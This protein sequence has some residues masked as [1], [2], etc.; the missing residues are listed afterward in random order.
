MVDYVNKSQDLL[1]LISLLRTSIDVRFAIGNNTF[2]VTSYPIELCN[3]LHSCFDFFEQWY[4][5]CSFGPCPSL[6][7]GFICNGVLIIVIRKVNIVRQLPPEQKLSLTLSISHD[8]GRIM[9][10]A[11]TR[12]SGKL[13]GTL[14]YPSCSEGALNDDEESTTAHLFDLKDVNHRWGTQVVELLQSLVE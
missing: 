11:T 7:R 12:P 9:W 5:F 10:P 4:F 3:L 14:V 13:L 8:V 6:D 1:E 2:N